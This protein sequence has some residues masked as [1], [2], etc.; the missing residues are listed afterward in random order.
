VWVTTVGEQEDRERTGRLISVAGLVM[1]AA[2]AGFVVGRVPGLQQ[3]GLGL[4]LAIL[5]DVSVVRL[6]L[7]PSLMEI[8]GRWNWWLPNPRRRAA[9]PCAQEGLAGERP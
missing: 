9:A 6:L 4:A 5:I 8:L 1:I 2:F 7:V 3:F